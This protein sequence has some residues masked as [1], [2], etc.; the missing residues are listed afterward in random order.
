M[1]ELLLGAGADAKA[2]DLVACCDAHGFVYGCVWV[3][4]GTSGVVLSRGM[5][6][7]GV[8]MGQGRCDMRALVAMRWMCDGFGCGFGVC[9]D[10]CV[11]GVCLCV[12]DAV[13]YVCVDHDGVWVADVV[14]A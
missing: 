5:L 9:A 7:S 6:V 8:D 3:N 10:V 13:V 2:A 14:V 1:V 4:M 12:C 11:V